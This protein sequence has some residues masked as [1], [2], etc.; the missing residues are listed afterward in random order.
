MKRGWYIGNFSPSALVTQQFEVCYTIHKKDEKW[1][2]HYHKV[3][4]EITLVIRG[5]MR[6]NN[7]VYGQGSII[8]IHPNEIAD[9]SFI[10]DTELVIVKTPSDIND[11]YTV[12]R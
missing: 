2:K 7:T 5:K 8:V 9:P 10:E 11:K 1:E 4:T 12:P 6:I 3:G